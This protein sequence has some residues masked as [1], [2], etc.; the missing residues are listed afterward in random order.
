MVEV[1]INLDQLNLIIDKFHGT[2][3]LIGTTLDIPELFAKLHEKLIGVDDRGDVVIR[4]CP[5]YI[6]ADLIFIFR[7]EVE[8]KHYI[9]KLNKIKSDLKNDMREILLEKIVGTLLLGRSEIEEITLNLAELLFLLES[10]ESIIRSNGI[11]WSTLIDNLKMYIKKWRENLQERD[12]DK[13][14]LV[15]L[16][17]S[18]ISIIKK[19]DDPIRPL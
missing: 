2:I 9:H 6:T 13:M 17:R 1:K 7:L 10:N 16:K 11:H 18:I 15:S 12:V 19:W 8:L 14:T 5:K 3:L 4:I